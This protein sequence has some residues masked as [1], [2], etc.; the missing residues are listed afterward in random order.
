MLNSDRLIR[1]NSV[2][3]DSINVARYAFVIPDATQPPAVRS[4][5]RRP[6]NLRELAGVLYIGRTTPD[7]MSHS[8]EPE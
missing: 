8:R 3:P 7:R 2:Q 1:D 4:A 5:G 6:Q